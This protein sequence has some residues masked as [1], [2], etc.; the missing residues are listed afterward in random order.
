MMAKNILFYI[1]LVLFPVSLFSLEVPI[2]KSV[3]LEIGIGEFSVIEF[4][5][6]IKGTNKAT[7]VPKIKSWAPEFIADDKCILVRSPPPSS[8]L[9]PQEAISSIDFK[10]FGSPAFAPSKSTT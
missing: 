10:F 7:F 4:P 3:T 8:T 9:I 6:A 2:N 5:F 1:L